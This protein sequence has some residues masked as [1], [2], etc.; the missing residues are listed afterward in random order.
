MPNY[1]PRALSDGPLHGVEAIVQLLPSDTYPASLEA[2]KQQ[3]CSDRCAVLAA[4]YATT[5]GI[6][7]VLCNNE[8]SCAQ[9]VLGRDVGRDGVHYAALKANCESVSCVQ[10]PAGE[11]APPCAVGEAPDLATG[12]C[13][14]PTPPN[15]LVIPSV[16]AT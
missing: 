13:A 6:Y 16:V 1:S 9:F 2:T 15:V 11:H 4:F 10:C 14:T 5:L 7:G 3:C 12:C 8:A